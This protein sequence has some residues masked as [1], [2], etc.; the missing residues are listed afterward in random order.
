M[1]GPKKRWLATNWL[2]SLSTSESPASESPASEQVGGGSAGAH[3]SRAAGPGASVAETHVVSRKELAR[4]YRR[5][6]YQR[7]KQ[8]RATDPKHLAMKEAVKVRR[9]EMYQQVKAQR[10]VRDAALETNRKAAESQS[11]A[12][13]KRQLAERV[14]SA[15]GRG[16]EPLSPSE[17]L[18]GSDGHL[19]LARD[20]DRA[21]RNAD[22]KELME[23]LRAES[24]ALAARHRDDDGTS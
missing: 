22:V 16:S 4:Q 20:I 18:P 19:A 10:K 8:A 13:A 12:E 24:P 23:R 21:L 1:E 3:T 14:K 6:A 9:R 15:I 17:L 5:Q 2:S 11:R 7:A